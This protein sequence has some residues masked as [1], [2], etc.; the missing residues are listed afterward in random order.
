MR[1]SGG[2]ISIRRARLGIPRRPTWFGL[3]LCPLIIVGCGL[4]S[5]QA[6]HWTATIEVPIASHQLDL[7]YI[8]SHS[9]L[10]GLKWSQDSGAFFRIERA[11]DTV[12]VGDHLTVAT[13]T[14]NSQFSVGQFAIGEGTRTAEALPLSDLYSGPVGLI[15]AFSAQTRRSLPA[16][17]GWISAE[18]QDGQIRVAVSNHLGVTLDSVAIAIYNGGGDTAL[19]NVSIGGPILTGDSAVGEAPLRPGLIV[20]QWDY[21]MSFYTPG[22]T[23]L[24]ADDKYVAVTADI[25]SGILVTRATAVISP[26][27][28]QYTDSLSLS[29]E[30]SLSEAVFG[31]G[32]IDIGWANTTPLPIA[33]QWVSPELRRDGISLSG[34]EVIGPNSS[35][36]RQIDLSGFHFFGSA[37]TS[38]ARLEMTVLSEGS[39]GQTVTMNSNDGVS[40][41]TVAHDIALESA[42]GALSP[43]RQ[44]VD[45]LSTAIAWPNGTKDLGL[46]SGTL[47]LSVTS[48]LPWP[49]QLEGQIANQSGL[50][51]PVGGVLQAGSPAHPVL[52]EITVPDVAAL[53]RPLPTEII[54]GGSITYGDGVTTGTVR[55]SDFV[56]PRLTFT[57]PADLYVDSVNLRPDIMW[58]NLATGDQVERR[59]RLKNAQVQV[60]VGNH[61][62]LGAV[63]TLRIASDSASAVS[64]PGIVF[65]PSVVTPAPTD[66]TGRTTGE[67]TSLLQYIVDSAHIALFEGQGVWIA[68]ELRLI[69]PGNGAASRIRPND[70]F[71]WSASARLE[72]RS[73]AE[74]ASGE[75]R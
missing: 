9:D 13:Q 38:S 19:A 58:A 7:A 63:L 31:S 45:H 10:E 67:S 48:T 26:L 32:R 24:T 40:V 47:I 66:H 33:V 23:I 56:A 55:A 18:V 16:V 1:L 17:S 41:Q 28:R 43:T 59:G 30:H 74:L 61:L 60:V 53:L 65:G 21:A 54:F 36:S 49:V 6:P 8:V 42:T 27:N 64:N 44:T 68:G 3:I 20:P 12:F 4:Q 14:G 73:E 70:Y 15:A 62:P 2:K 50:T 5:P 29:R 22:G 37:A 69:G 25:P 71:N 34:S 11:L 39:G 35:A 57:S 51:V 52:T 72:V 75:T 46:D